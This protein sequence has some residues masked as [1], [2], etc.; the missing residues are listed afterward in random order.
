VDGKEYINER[1]TST[2]QTGFSFVA[3][4]RGALPGP[5][6]G[7][8]W[9]GVDDTAATVYVPMYAGIA[10]PRATSP[11]ARARSTG[12]DWESA[13]GCST[14]WQLY[15]SALPDMIV[16]VQKVQRELEGDFANRQAAVDAAA[17]ELYKRSPELARDY[18]TRYSHE[19]AE[20]T[21]KR[22]RKLGED[23][24]VKYMDGNIK[25]ELGA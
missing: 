15:L 7:V 5:I 4:S 3:Q 18:L 22:W 11:W 13:S 12:S 14:G 9:F 23:L 8:L 2:Q 19:A 17:L 6:G 20:R 21:V 25:D 10:R 16:D 1:S 24:L